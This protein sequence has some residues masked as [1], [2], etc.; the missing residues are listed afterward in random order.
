MQG[1]QVFEH[2]PVLA[3]E[4]SIGLTQGIRSDAPKTILFVDCTLGAAGHS[5]LLVEQ[6]LGMQ[7]VEGVKLIGFD[8]DPAAR[9]ASQMRLDSLAQKFNKFS[10]EIISRNFS[11]ISDVFQ[12]LAPASIDILLADIGV[13]SHQLD[14][15]NRGFSIHSRDP[16]DMRMNPSLPKSAKHLLLEASQEELESIFKNFGEEPRARHLAKCILSDRQNSNESRRIPVHSC[17]ELSAYFNRVLGYKDSRASPSIRIFQALRI[18][19]NDELGALQALLRALPSLMSPT[20]ATGLISFH[21]LEDRI[22][23]NA[24]RS[25]ED[26]EPSLGCEF[27][28]GGTVAAHDEISDNPR[29]RSARLRVFYWGRT[30]KD[31]RKL[32]KGE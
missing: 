1:E 10:Y 21:S 17:Q 18:A 22:V 15:G 7:N 25:W 23:K 14:S 13:S 6:M 16:V 24:Y 28:R 30:R 2:K 31:A 4:V 5:A 11:E 32:F 8:Q 20:G 26:S 12:H 29:A 27:P 9:Q 3:R 19:V